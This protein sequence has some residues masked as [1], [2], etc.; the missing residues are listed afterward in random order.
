MVDAVPTIKSGGNQYSTIDGTLIPV[1]GSEINVI[2]FYESAVAQE[3]FTDL[4]LEEIG[5]RELLTLARHETLTG[6]AVA[7]NTPIENITEVLLKN[8]SINISPNI[9]SVTDYFDTFPMLLSQYMPT[10]EELDTENTY[11]Y[12]K[13]YVYF[14]PTTNTIIFNVVTTNAGERVQV[15]FVVFDSLKNDTI[16]T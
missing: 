1:S 8:S 5:G 10:E 7:K 16:Y 15:E 2:G 4:I 11:F 9:N 6:G 3:A 14:E 12:Q 13:E